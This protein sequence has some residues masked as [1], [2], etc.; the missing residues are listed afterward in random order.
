[1]PYAD[2][3]FYREQFCGLQID[4]E[5][6][7]LSAAEKADCYLDWL[8]NGKTR[9]LREIPD[10]VKRAECAVSELYQTACAARGLHSEANDGYQVVYSEPDEVNLYRE[11]VRY[12][13]TGFAYRGIGI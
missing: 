5:E 1:M 11:A 9:K 4:S 12:L 7:Y 10:S 2:F 6:A 3:T 8:T 13:P